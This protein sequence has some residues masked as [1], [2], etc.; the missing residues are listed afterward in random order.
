MNS[1][2]KQPS[3][4]SGFALVLSL[5]L[6]AFILVLILS[7]STLVQVETSSSAIY[8]SKLEAE[9]RALLGLKIALGELQA[10]MGPDQRVSASADISAANRLDRKRTIGVWSTVTDTNIGVTEGQLVDW[11]ISD[12]RDDRGEFQRNFATT[13]P[14]PNGVVLVGAGSLLDA[15]N[16]G[17]VDDLNDQVIIEGT[18]VIDSR[19]NVATGKYGWWIGDE[20]AKARINLARE[21]SADLNIQRQLTVL[22][23]ASPSVT[24]A[25]ALAA[26]NSV[27]FQ[28]AP[29]RVVDLQSAELLQ[30]ADSDD[31]KQHFFDLT[32]WSVGLPV[33]VKSGSLKTDLSLAFEMPDDLFNQSIFAAAGDTPITAPG[34]GAVQP[35]FTVANDTGIDA[36]GPAWHLLRDYY[37][38]YHLM[39]DP[40]DDPTLDARVFGP[41]LNHGEDDLDITNRLSASPADIDQ[42]PAIIMAGGK[43]KFFGHQG[44][45][46]LMDRVGGSFVGQSQRDDH[47]NR[48]QMAVDLTL[49]DSDPARLGVEGDPLRGGGRTARGTTMPVMVT[50]NYTPYMLRFIGE[51]G[52]WFDTPALSNPAPLTNPVSFNIAQR[53]RFIMHNP[54]N[55]TLRHDEIAI[56][57]F[58]GDVQF[59]LYDQGDQYVQFQWRQGSTLRGTPAEIDRVFMQSSRRQ[60][61]VADGEFDPGEIK[62]FNAGNLGNNR[63]DSLQYAQDGLNPD[64]H[65]FKFYD[66]SNSSNLV[67]ERPTGNLDALNVAV[68]GS[69]M[70]GGASTPNY[71]QDGNYTPGDYEYSHT[72]LFF[73]T[74]F[75]QRGNQPFDGIPIRDRWPMASV[76]DTTLLLPGPDYNAGSEAPGPL[77]NFFPGTD[78]SVRYYPQ[79]LNNG[80]NIKPI[81]PTLIATA[82]SQQRAEPII[83]LDVQLK[84]AEYDRN[85]TRYP[86]FAHSNPLAPIRDNKN[87]LPE[88]DFQDGEIEG[89]PRLSPDMSADFTDSGE[90]SLASEYNFWG[91][92]DGLA[93]TPNSPV[94]IE[95]PTAPVQ[96]IGKLQH[97]NI[98]L[99]AHMPAL[100]VGNSLASVYIDPSETTRVFNN[101]YGN[102]RVF[103]DLSYLMNEALWDDYFFS[104]L[105]VPYTP[106]ED[107]YNEFRDTPADMFDNY[108]E[109]LVS[110]PNSR[111]RFV[112]SADN[113]VTELRDKLFTGRQIVVDA[114]QRVAEN[115]VIDGSF[116]V[117]STSVDAW[118]AVLSGARGLAVYRSNR[119]PEIQLDSDI[120]PFPRQSLPVG[121][122][123]D[124]T[125]S[126]DAAWSGFRALSDDDIENLAGEIVAELINRAGNN[127]HPYL[128]LSDFVNRELSAGAE[129]RSGLLQAAIDNSGLNRVFDDVDA[130]RINVG[131]LENEGTG[132]FDF[133][134][135]ILDAGGQPGN[136]NR[137]APTYLMQAD[138][139]QA[140]GAFISVRSDTFRI[141]SYGDS[142]DPLTGDVN[143]R[144]WYE[145]IVQRMPSPT[146]PEP[147]TTPDEPDFWKTQNPGGQQHVFGRQFRIV[148]IRQLAADEV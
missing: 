134:Q 53:E 60:I 70:H 109:N 124:N 2:L 26:L 123:W 24:D 73:A 107:D 15:N 140:I 44:D 133:A 102:Q 55:V 19:R 148:S 125:A 93:G 108:F 56:D 110:L 113:G 36:N 69:Y 141:R 22:E 75:K 7:I 10:S 83:T 39:E 115:I 5:S 68:F 144:V 18:D 8:K 74:H 118:R 84:S 121:E 35:V 105:S 146:N 62:T 114:P 132:A 9:Q 46:N 127:G 25:S 96:S 106:G 90:T 17:V 129:G 103:Y 120:T 4:Q 98:S 139:L 131:D 13:A 119:N 112:I 47:P 94:L 40:M 48:D 97:A 23:M 16:D 59:H 87:L 33:N 50:G 91:P 138:I 1:L 20:G 27:N 145:A 76:I 14:N 32:T 81:T 45:N 80:K 41:N 49:I 57:S 31:L 78:E 128:S 61:R 126:S 30:N 135:N 52:I 100:A 29:G 12:A 34:F 66:N 64:W 117:N 143:S 28:E 122:E 11:L 101:F 37:R 92:T 21:T 79:Y 72:S 116:N 77:E 104:S 51:T 65:H 58:A 137:A 38:L 67:F 142:I 63:G 43:V 86:A 95:L 136:A 111:N 3:R 42:Q 71:S 89:F 147:G 6:M 54:Y 88:D 130:S 99:H 82:N 85:S